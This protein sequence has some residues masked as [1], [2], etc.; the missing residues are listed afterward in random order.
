MHPLVRHV[1]ESRFFRLQSTDLEFTGIF[2]RKVIKNTNKML[3][4]LNSIRR[5]AE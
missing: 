4:T 1:I 3:Q 2:H 5:P